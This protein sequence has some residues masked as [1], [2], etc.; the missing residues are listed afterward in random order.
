MYHDD[1]GPG[2]VGYMQAIATRQS[3]G[4]WRLERKAESQSYSVASGKDLKPPEVVDFDTLLRM[5]ADFNSM[6]DDFNTVNNNTPGMNF[7][8]VKDLMRSNTA[9]RLQ[10]IRQLRRTPRPF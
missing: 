7:Q 6:Y 9:G 1:H 5:M 2:Y 10:A 3:D 8:T 4:M